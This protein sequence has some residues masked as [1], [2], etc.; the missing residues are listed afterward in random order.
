MRHD[1]AFL[2]RIAVTFTGAMPNFGIGNFSFHAPGYA[3]PPGEI[4]TARSQATGTTVEDGTHIYTVKFLAKQPGN[5]AN[6][7]WLWAN[8][9]VLKPR[10]YS[11]PP[12]TSV[13]LDIAYTE[14][15]ET[16]ATVQP[17]ASELVTIYPNPATAT[18]H[19]CVTL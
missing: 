8:H 12:L 4:R 2:E 17:T 18:T 13:G 16:S 11:T 9:P 7:F 15:G 10:A 19:F 3:N 6:K 1:T 5:L 14:T